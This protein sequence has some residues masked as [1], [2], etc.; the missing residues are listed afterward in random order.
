MSLQTAEC[1][2]HNICLTPRC[3]KWVYP[4]VTY[5]N[6]GLEITGKSYSGHAPVQYIIAVELPSGQATTVQPTQ[7]T[8][9]H[10]FDFKTKKVVFMNCSNVHNFNTPFID[11]VKGKMNNR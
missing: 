3:E 1:C 4:H 7:T 5:T 10:L 8:I 2:V 6:S 9:G 11:F